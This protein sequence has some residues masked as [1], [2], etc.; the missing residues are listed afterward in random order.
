[1]KRSDYV[2]KRLLELIEALPEWVPRFTI[3]VIGGMIGALIV[4]AVAAWLR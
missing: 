3:S 1:M 4:L 2:T